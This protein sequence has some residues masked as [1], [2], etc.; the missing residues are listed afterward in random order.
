MANRIGSFLFAFALGTALSLPA[1]AGAAVEQWDFNGDLESSVGGDALTAEAAA[2]AAAPGV[3]FEV[4]DIDG[5]DADVASFTRGTYFRLRHRL[6]AN[7]G[8]QHLNVYTLIMDVMFPD[9]SASG[10]WAVLFQT[11][12]ANSGDGDWFVNPGSG[13]GISGNYGGS[14][15]AGEWH[16]LAL[17]V[18][19]PAGTFTSYVDGA[20][21]QQN[22]GQAVDG[23]FSLGEEAL[24]F[25]DEDQEN[26]AGLVNSVQLLNYAMTSDDLADLGGP[27]AAGI[28]L[29][30][31]EECRVTDPRQDC[32]ANDVRDECDLRTGASLDCNANGVPDEC[33]IAT[34]ESEDCDKNGVPDEC[35]VAKRDCDGDGIMDG[36]EIAE[37]PAKDCDGNG[38]LDECQVGGVIRFEFNGDLS[39]ASGKE[40]LEE[41]FAVPAPEA[42][43]EFE[44]A[45][46]GGED[47]LVAH[48]S[49]GTYF[50]MVNDLPANG[51]GMFL[52]QYTLILDVMFPDRSPSGGWA[53]LWQT[54]PADSDDGDW[55]INPGNGVG[56]SGN[57]GGSVLAG[58]WHRLALVVDLAAGSFT[59]YVDGARVQQNAGIGGADGR[60][61]AREFALLFADEDQENAE[62]YVNS[63]QLR[64]YAMSEDEIAGMGG[65]TAA[66]IPWEDC[67]RNAI[68]DVCDIHS[69]TSHD[70]NRNGLP[71]ECEGITG[72]PFIRG[73]TNAS[74]I[75]DLADPIYSLN[76]QFAGGPE[77][78]CMASADTNASG[79]VDLAD[80]IYCLNYQF[81][82]GPPMPPPNVC[83]IVPDADCVSFAACR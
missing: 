74:G 67:N 23:R 82:G 25:A 34:G 58:E 73:D 30:P 53:A 71:D 1:P 43:V 11:N 42:E 15:L 83:G 62:G 75:V 21:V 29:P 19:L 26:A 8:G 63:V 60:F 41:L 18:D 77:P 52:N 9:R 3:S 16:R 61:A 65:P 13:V 66:G 5:E 78:S 70:T 56:I 49:R 45:D 69:G 33:D 12:P 68:P 28:P 48:F 72:V 55:F 22:T 81:A 17:V 37:D 54:N 35:E 10:G 51:G 76:Y 39:E 36:C 64:G 59:C 2:P 27:S 24:L 80:P 79:L 7:G 46:I 50:R 20:F 32:N 40:P 38:I 44:T 57:Y 14:V 31:E 47:A 4:R 6:G